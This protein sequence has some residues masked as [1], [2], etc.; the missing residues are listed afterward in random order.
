MGLKQSVVIVNQ[1]TVKTGSK[2]GSRGGSPGNYVLSYMAREGG[3]EE[4]TPAKLREVDSY[5]TRYMA[6]D[7]AVETLDSIPD[8]KRS[9]KK[10]QK[11]GGLAFGYGDVALSDEKLRQASRD[12]QQQF[13]AGKTCFKTVISFDEEYLREN[14]LIPEDFK[15]EKRGDYR[16]NLDQLKL[17][18]AIMHGL[19]RMGHRFDDLQYVG[20]IQVDTLHVH[21]HLCMVDRG[22]GRL[23]NDL[24]QRGK[25]GASD[26]QLLRR[27]IDNFLDRKQ[28][29]RMMSSSV[30]QSRQ[31]AVCYIK[32]FAHETLA[33][34]GF[35]QFL[36]ACLPVNKNLW[37]AST[38]RVE[39]KKANTIVKEYV[40]ELFKR[41]DSGYKESVAQV[42]EYTRYRRD[43][44]G[45]TDAEATK[46][47]EIGKR[48]ILERG[49]NTVYDALKTIPSREF[50]TRTAMLESMSMDYESMA[51]VSTNDPML[52]FGF[53]LRSYSN[54]M[55]H[56]RKE[57]H[58]YRDEYRT[59]ELTENKAPE[60]EALGY[61]LQVEQEYQR[62]LMVKYQNFLTFLPPDEEF[63]EEL[64]ERLRE[65][66]RLYNLKAMIADSNM[67]KM[68]PDVAEDYGVSVYGQ[69]GGHRMKNNMKVLHVRAEK[70]EEQIEKREKAFRDKLQDY[71]FDFN[72][73]GL[74]RANEYDF[75]EVKA[76][77]LHHLG[78]DFAYDI[79]VSKFNIDNFG[80]AAQM[81]FD[82]FQAAK[83]YLVQSGQ[84]N[85]VKLLP[86][87][88]VL[89]MKQYADTIGAQSVLTSSRTANNALEQ[90]MSRTIS[91]NR[92]YDISLSSFVKSAIASSEIEAREMQ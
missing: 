50:N 23:A 63:E 1:Y 91:L 53:K 54:R 21:C 15:C 58:K 8:I 62:M 14:G 55:R 83:E 57:Y 37:R 80:Y 64:H 72:G 69:R 10:A 47:F 31:N 45:L 74:C 84:E 35:A 79:P 85:T 33:N 3:T 19:E 49:M 81:R 32:K 17:R 4:I 73:V 16:G 48:Q 76:L 65:R 9:M 41:D 6:R 2:T 27:G 44:E 56:H 68:D 89:Y 86:E 67:L 11:H 36:L 70:F 7:E 20:V 30:Q 71:G 13:D 61:Y 90:K 75:D 12:I 59:Y 46:I 24:T 43:R 78:Y 28:K 82:A 5:I 26:K 18:M 29:V 40:E 25:L 60:S 34:R 66:K 22:P 92:D 52:E 51:N 88:D 77:D 38:N 39:M 42:E 87:K